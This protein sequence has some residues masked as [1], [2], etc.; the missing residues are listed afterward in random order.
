MKMAASIPINRS[1]FLCTLVS[2]TYCSSLMRWT[3]RQC[4]KMALACLQDSPRR[5]QAH[6]TGSYLSCMRPS[7]LWLRET[8]YSC[9]MNTFV[10]RL[11]NWWPRFRSTFRRACYLRLKTLYFY[12]L[13][14][15]SISFLFLN[16]NISASKI[17]KANS[18]F[19]F[20]AINLCLIFWF[21]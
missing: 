15:I 9:R 2:C 7:F 17:D 18:S 13:I 4:R 5:S 14:K 6:H 20:C 21:F 10:S 8:C 12:S 1:G 3:C 19:I 16:K 11:R